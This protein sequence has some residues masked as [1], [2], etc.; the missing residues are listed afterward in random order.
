MS[1]SE[2]SVRHHR[3]ETD[4]AIRGA[5]AQLAADPVAL[6][7]FHELLLCARQRAS[8]LFEAPMES[9]RHLGV[10]A[11]LHLSRFRSSHV[12]DLAGWQGTTGS[13]RVAVSLLA[14]QLICKYRVPV[15]LSSA[16][17]AA[18][19]AAERKRRWYVAHARGAS[20]RSLN[21]PMAM[22]RKMEHIFLGSADHLP[23]EYALRRAELAALGVPAGFAREILATRLAMDLRH[24]EFWR[25][26][27]RFL[28]AHAGGVD[29]SQIG[30]IID[31]IQTVRHERITA[32]T[33][34]GTVE[35]DPPQPA[36]S[37]KGRTIQSIQRQMHAWHRNLGENTAGVSWA[38][39]PYESLLFE[40]SSRDGSEVPERWQLLEL[41]NS[42]QLRS[43]GAALHHCVASYA[44]RCCR[45]T[46]SIWSLRLWRGEKV[47]SVLTIEIDPR[48]RAVVQVRG[49]ANRAAS[50][51]P[52]R[53]LADWA[54][55]ERLL[56]VV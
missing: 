46:S 11:L 37:M 29:P 43:E 56:M 2:L 19:S 38:R 34:D 51:K 21:L 47:R 24:S 50:G 3:R 40:E 23:I 22:T 13:W 6:K 54:V 33:R 49:Y 31:Y 10:E 28:I 9:G 7:T 36:F 27:W 32:M 44:D 52:L 20:F 39:S 12:R 15:F 48:R 5:F 30:P 35:L 26:L 55:R 4:C 1:W 8:H 41:T 45:G 17:Y 16:W 25:T 18:D 14:H 42:N 53:L